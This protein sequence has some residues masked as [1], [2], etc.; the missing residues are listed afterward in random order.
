[1]FHPVIERHLSM[2]LGNQPRLSL[3]LMP[4]LSWCLPGYRPGY[5][6]ARVLSVHPDGATS[7][8]LWLKPAANWPGFVPGQSIEL[9]F[10]NNG[11]WLSRRFSISSSL[12]QWQREGQIRLTIKINPQGQLS[13]QLPKLIAEG[14]L[15]WLSISPAAG[16]FQWHSPASSSLMLAA[17]SG[18]TPLASMLLSQRCW[19]APVTLLYYVRQQAEAALL[20]E[21]QQLASAQP[22]FRLQLVETA[23]AGRQP[24][25]EVLPDAADSQQLLT[26]GP[27]AFTEAALA[28]GA[29]CGLKPADCQREFFHLPPLVET[30][31]DQQWQVRWQ[32]AEQQVVSDVNASQSLLDQAEQAGLQPSF[33]CRMGV[34]YQ[35]VCQKESGVVLNLRTGQRSTAGAEQ[36]Q[37]CVSV[38][39]SAL[40]IRLGVSD[41]SF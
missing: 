32:M 33:G 10:D 20:A 7:Y 23:S 24:F 30:A 34:C 16:D 39:Q 12:Q 4:L 19:T 40:S 13:R 5:Y 11:R 8:S 2:L 1:M 22:L 36:I 38:P 41:A 25:A 6:R 21:L 9:G 14:A 37:L 27:Y 17:G 31:G 35:C 3:A 15:R 28:F 26:C 18:I 29:A